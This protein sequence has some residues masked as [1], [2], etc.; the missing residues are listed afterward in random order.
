MGFLRRI[1]KSKNEDVDLTK[2][3]IY[4]NY[5]NKYSSDEILDLI[6]S[7]KNGD[8]FPLD[9]HSYLV[10]NPEVVID[11]LEDGMNFD[12]YDWSRYTFTQ[13]HQV[14][15]GELE[16]IDTSIYNNPECFD[17][18]QMLA[19]RAGITD[20]VNINLYKNSEYDGYKMLL[21]YELLKEG[22]DISKALDPR[23]NENQ[24]NII[25]NIAPKN[26]PEKFFNPEI[27]HHVMNESIYLYFLGYAIDERLLN[28]NTEVMD[29]HNQTIRDPKNK[30]LTHF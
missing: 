24:I 29:F 20:N 21:Y 10:A 26:T 6:I 11:A 2:F 23:L 30:H 1:F 4:P 9:Q 28:K 15:R 25:V 27:H 17:G 8:T 19:L 22:K 13:A 5:W 14:F 7:T 3:G 18:G 12:D 16:G